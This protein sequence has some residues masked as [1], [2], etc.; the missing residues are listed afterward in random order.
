MEKG[1]FEEKLRSK[2]LAN[3]KKN[4]GFSTAH[5]AQPVKIGNT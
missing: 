2:Q 1:I 4:S 5:N 3:R